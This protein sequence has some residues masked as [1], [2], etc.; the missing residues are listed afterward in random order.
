MPLNGG[1]R[2]N[3]HACLGKFTFHETAKSPSHKLLPSEVTPTS[4]LWT[5]DE[6]GQSCDSLLPSTN[7]ATCL[8]SYDKS[9]RKS[10]SWELR[11]SALGTP[12][13]NVTN[14]PA[15]YLWDSFRVDPV[16]SESKY[17]VRQ[18]LNNVGGHISSQTCSLDRTSDFY[19]SHP[20]QGLWIR[21]A[22]YISVQSDA[23]CVSYYQSEPTWA[24]RGATDNGSR[25]ST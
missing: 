7:T 16:S 14:P 6:S 22:R 20:V 15:I 8:G 4:N 17:L 1:P 23:S 12:P 18:L 2:Q 21:C 10:R 25:C 13:R 24:A 3:I 9:S 11:L 19:I 5:N